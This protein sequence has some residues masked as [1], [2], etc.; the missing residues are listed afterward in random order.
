MNGSHADDVR[1]FLVAVRDGRIGDARDLLAA[2]PDLPRRSAHVAAAIGDAQALA[3]QLQREAARATAPDADGWHPLID[4]CRSRW[5]ALDSASAGGSL[6]CLRL[7]LDHGADPSAFAPDPNEPSWRLPALYEACMSDNVPVVAMLLERGADPN[8]GESLY[9]AA[10]HG[11]RACLELLLEHGADVSGRHGLWNNTPLYFLAGHRDADPLAATAT[12]GMRWLL[13]HGA[14]PNVPSLPSGETP[15]HRV[16]VERSTGVIDLLLD[17]GADAR[18]PRADGRTAYAIAVRS[19]NVAAA[20]LLEQRGAATALTPADAFLGA[21]MRADEPAARGMLA[22]RPGLMDEL[23]PAD[24]A[25]VGLAAARGNAAAVRLMA[26]LGFDATRETHEGT[27]LHRAA[28]RGHA[29]AVRALLEL[30]A[31]VNARD[32]TYGSS[33]LG[34]AAHGAGHFR[35]HGDFIATIDALLDAGATFEAAVNRWGVPAAAFAPPEVA[36]H[37]RRRGG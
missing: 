25:A 10:Q 4:L 30:G 26:A 17:H 19:G 16:V 5:H 18:L 3:E 8:D 23:D 37:L 33:A 28:W 2:A 29:E 12:G 22:E 6:A 27:P 36:E 31:P 21:C 34:W 35:N 1:R 7:L 9:H 14:D 13:E 32:A 11:R 15:L 24:R 20:R